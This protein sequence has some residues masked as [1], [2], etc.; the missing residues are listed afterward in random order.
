MQNGSHR[1][2]ELQITIL[3]EITFSAILSSNSTKCY[4]VVIRWNRVY[5]TNSTN[6]YNIKLGL[7]DKQEGHDGPGSL[8]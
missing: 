3:I 7:I 1:H 2:E 6:D 4:V 5:E 8:T